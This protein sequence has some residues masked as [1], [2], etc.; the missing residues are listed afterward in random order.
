[1]VGDRRIAVKT[2]VLARN[3][4]ELAP[5]P[6]LEHADMKI[7]LSA[8]GSRGDVQPLVAIALELRALG[9]EPRF[10][11]PP[12]FTPWVE[13]FGFDCFPIGPDL[14]Q[15][16]GG[17]APKR[18]P[19][20]T[21]TA[22]QRR[23]LAAHTVRSQFP[24]LTQ[25]ASGCDLVVGATALQFA[26]RSVAES[27][28]IAYVF[29]AFCPVV[30]PSPDHPPPKIGMH[31]DPSSPP[32]A[33]RSLWIED[34]QSWND[35]F[36]ESVNEERA[37]LGLAAIDSVRRHIFTDR[38]WLAADAVLA[39]AAASDDLHIVQTG[40]WLLSDRSGLPDEIEAFLANG[41]PPI[42]FGFGSMSAAE[43]TSRTFVE[44]ARALGRR[45]IISQGWANLAR[46]DAG[47][48]CLSVGDIAHDA[49][50]ARVAAIVHHGGAG[51]TT[52]AARAGKP[53][54]VLPHTYDQFYWA[55]RVR[56]LGIGVAGP[57]HAHLTVDAL[58]P[59]LQDCLRPAIAAN[60]PTL[61]RRVVSSGAARAARRLIDE[62][63]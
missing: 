48:D 7:L 34:E 17:T 43:P 36:R 62:F 2:A 18:A 38:P 10:C 55:D 14:K 42:Y 40:A 6:T 22:E 58:I 57:E 32:D 60:A 63:A 46:A 39:P 44:A 37:A 54:V 35:L 26:T 53:Q 45:S 20:Q 3:S 50:F 24:V 28:G 19:A 15:L 1:M 4:L 25:A 33:N 27:L 61:A 41:D 23:Q 5:F 31:H 16:T 9:H 49:L 29:V 52:A 59:A 13:S 56:S 8:I 30:L 47:V 12:N 11:V 51:T 21:P